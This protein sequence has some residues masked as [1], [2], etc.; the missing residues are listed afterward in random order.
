M[1][2][3]LR[4]HRV[5]ARSVPTRNLLLACNWSNVSRLAWVLFSM[6]LGHP[7]LQY[8]RPVQSWEHRFESTHTRDS[9]LAAWILSS[10]FRPKAGRGLSTSSFDPREL[11][12][13]R[14]V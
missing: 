8:Q 11:L 1:E 6:H 3:V 2:N 14:E 5:N 12:T 9:D 10:R 4:L 13:Q 7:Y